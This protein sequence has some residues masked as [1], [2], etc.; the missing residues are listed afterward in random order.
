MTGLSAP[1]HAIA[2]LAQAF[3]KVNRAAIQARW[4]AGFQAAL[5]ELE[6]FES[7]AQRHR[8]RIACPARRV[9]VQAD[10]DFAVQKRPRRQHHGFAAKAHADLGDG[11]YDSVALHHQII[12]R[13]LEQPE[14]GLIFQLVA[15]R[16][17]VQH[18]VGLRPGCP[19]SRAFGAVEDAE[20]D[21]RFVGRQSHRATHGVDF[22]DQVAF[23]D[24]ANGRVAAH[25]PQR[26]DVV[27]QEQGFAAHAGAGQCGLGASVAATDDDDVKFLGVIH[28]V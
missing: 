2:R 15:N 10:V 8:W 1:V 21:A 13:L 6:F 11:T 18:T 27:R 9:V 23:A 20:L 28:G 17:F 16:R 26:L 22:F 4:R 19:H 3:V 12:H 7:R 5:W 24:T 25:L 14:I